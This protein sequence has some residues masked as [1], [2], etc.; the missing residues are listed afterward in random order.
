MAEIPPK[1]GR[2]K[3]QGIFG[4]LTAKRSILCEL[5]NYS[6]KNNISFWDIVPIEEVPEDHLVKT[7]IKHNIALSWRGLDTELYG[8]NSGKYKIDT[9]TVEVEWQVK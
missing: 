5:I 8:S 1:S 2:V 4:T 7:A 3:I 6:S 9:E